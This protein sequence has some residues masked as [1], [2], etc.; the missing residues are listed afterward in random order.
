MHY[1]MFIISMHYK[2]RILRQV[3]LHQLGVL[4]HLLVQS[5]IFEGVNVHSYQCIYTEGAIYTIFCVSATL[6]DFEC[7]LNI[8]CIDSR[9]HVPLFN[10]SMSFS[11]RF[12]SPQLSPDVLPNSSS[13]VCLY[14]YSHFYIIHSFKHSIT[15]LFNAIY[16]SNCQVSFVL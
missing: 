3:N 5:N 15:T 4:I 12:I 6:R 8:L 1:F 16:F 14:T 10:D 11:L 2:N 9:F 13:L 7:W